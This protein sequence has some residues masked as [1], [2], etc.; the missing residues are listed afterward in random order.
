MKLDFILIFLSILL[1]SL[2]GLFGKKGALEIERFTVINAISNLNYLLSL[3]CLGLQAITWQIALKKYPL[4]FAYS[5]MSGV[6]VLILIFSF[7]V[8]HES[9]SLNNILGTVIIMIGIIFLSMGNSN[10]AQGGQGYKNK[11]LPII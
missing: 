3:V 2:S 11:W 10:K 7:F 5:F 9:I 6:Y 4:S 1:Q 8:F